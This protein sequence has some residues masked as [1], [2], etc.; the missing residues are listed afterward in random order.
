MPRF[1]HTTIALPSFVFM[2]VVIGACA[3]PGGVIRPPQTDE[4]WAGLITGWLLVALFTAAVG[5]AK[6]HSGAAAFFYGLLV[7]PIALLGVLLTSAKKRCPQCAEKIRKKAK[8]C[9]HCGHKL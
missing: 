1:L 4:E 5:K 2:T 8:V 7:G 9:K 6:G 3:G